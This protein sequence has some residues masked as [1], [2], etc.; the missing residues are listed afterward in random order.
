ML[1]MTRGRGACTIQA[2]KKGIKINVVVNTASGIVKNDIL[3]KNAIME[4][5]RSGLTLP[6]T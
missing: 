6:G 3:K 1:E 2:D 5:L 4:E